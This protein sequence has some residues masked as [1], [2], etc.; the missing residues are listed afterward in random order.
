MKTRSEKDLYVGNIELTRV[1]RLVAEMLCGGILSALSVGGMQP[2][3]LSFSAVS[4]NF[5]V[6]GVL[7]GYFIFSGDAYR[8][9]FATLFCFIL[10]RILTKRLPLNSVAN[11]FF[12]SVW[13]TLTAELL[14][15]VTVRYT[16]TEN[17]LFALSGLISGGVASLYGIAFRKQ[18]R[19]T[20]KMKSV[21]LFCRAVFIASL[22]AGIASLEGVLVFTSYVLSAF[23]LLVL[24]R[25][26][27]LLRAF[28]MAAVIDIFFLLSGSSSYL[29]M[30]SLVCI[31]L[32]SS[33]LRDLPPYIAAAACILSSLLMVIYERGSVS[34]WGDLICVAA[35]SALF[36]ALPGEV[37]SFAA[38]VLMPRNL[39]SSSGIKG[40]RRKYKSAK[41]LEINPV[42]DSCPKKF[43]CWVRDH[44]YTADVFIKL[45]RPDH[46]AVPSHFAQRCHRISELA[47]FLSANDKKSGCSKALF[48]KA[49]AVKRG[50]TSCGDNAGYFSVGEGKY[51]VCILDGMG[52]GAAASSDSRTCSVLLR[53]LLTRGVDKK[54][55][56]RFINE[57][58]M[59]ENRERVL[60]V[61][62]MTVDLNSGYMDVCKAGAAPTYIA[63][64]GKIYELGASSLPIGILDDVDAEASR[65]RISSG[66]ILVMVSDGFFERGGDWMGKHLFDR[67][68][69]GTTSC[70]ELAEALIE[71]ACGDGLDLYDDLT[72]VAVNIL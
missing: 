44:D 8:Y 32:A 67:I 69:A 19:L 63:R 7:L 11:A 12:F 60:G 36:V 38:N 9:V 22:L 41:G 49:S 24:G 2:F 54:E 30:G 71:D 16:F 25:C 21:G 1:F 51:V 53:K 6:V 34:A 68:A 52:S 3:G 42:C 45:K 15:V 5:G 27:G 39:T 28:T 18:K 46:S 66:D 29:M 59:R 62:I 4:G 35:S 47:A 17:I 43:I 37:V 48:A 33:L 57:Q 70:A 65:C 13:G 55:A 10:K 56:V 26:A 58:L 50:E 20:P 14:G 31:A 61:D 40:E 23:S 64:G 72:V